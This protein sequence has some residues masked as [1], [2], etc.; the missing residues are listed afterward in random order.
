[1]LQYFTGL[2]CVVKQVVKAQN[3]HLFGP[4]PTA[5]V[6]DDHITDYDHLICPSLILSTHSLRHFRL[7]RCKALL[8]SR[9]ISHAHSRLISLALSL[10][11]FL[12][13]S[14]AQ[15]HALIHRRD[16]LEL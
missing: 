11:L 4:S 16:V 3:T 14:C 9:I 10:S 7:S 15:S 2:C 13:L 12:S 8:I 1:M 6:Q 5:E